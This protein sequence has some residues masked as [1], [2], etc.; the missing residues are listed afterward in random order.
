M[1]LLAVN[2]RNSQGCKYE[3]FPPDRYELFSKLQVQTLVHIWYVSRNLDTFKFNT[4]QLGTVSAY[5]MS[6]VPWSNQRAH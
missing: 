4:N 6:A 3:I 1:E 2:V 5:V